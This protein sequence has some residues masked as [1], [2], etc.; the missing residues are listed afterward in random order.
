MIKKTYL[1]NTPDKF[2]AKRGYESDFLRML[3]AMADEN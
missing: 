3:T 2:D 1:G